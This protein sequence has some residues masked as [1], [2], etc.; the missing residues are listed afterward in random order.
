MA[1]DLGHYLVALVQDRGLKSPELTGE[2]EAKLREIELGRLDSR[3]FMAEIVEYTGEVI[4]HGDA[5]SVDENRLGDCP[6]CGR[7]V[8]AGKRGFGCSRWREGCQ[9]VMWR[10]YKGHSLRDDQIRRLLQRRVLLEP[11]MFWESGEVVIQLLDNG[12][13]AEIPVPVGG[14]HRRTRK[15]GLRPGGERTRRGPR[16]IATGGSERGSSPRQAIGVRSSQ[17]G[18]MPAVRFGGRGAGQVLWLQRL[19]AWV[20][21]CDLEDDR[22]QANHA[23]DGPVAPQAGRT[24]L[25]KGFV[26]KSGKRFEA[27]L[28]LEGGDVRFDFGS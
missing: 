10:E 9:F 13:L 23:A 17:V 3:R 6:R 20:Q 18:P 1:T 2:W 14:Q 7:P 21:V 28:R 11:P 27:R 16:E 5:M 15:K 26:S 22:R 24:P 25:L 19:A 4:R 8:I 12:E